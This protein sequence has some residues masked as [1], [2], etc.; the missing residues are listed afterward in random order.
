[1]NSNYLDYKKKFD[2]YGYFIFKNFLSKIFV[3][4][5]ID[6]INKASYTEKYFDNTNKLRRIEKIY[7]KGKNLIDLN[8]KILIFLND[9]FE[10][11]FT[12]FKDKFNCKPPGGEGFLP[13]MMVYL[14]L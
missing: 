9:I 3:L 7:D 6:D 4:K 5:L 11:N 13:I 1:M 12:I 10:T 2:K 8:N 14:D